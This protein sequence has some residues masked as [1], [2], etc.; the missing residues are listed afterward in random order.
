MKPYVTGAV[1]QMICDFHFI[2]YPP[3]KRKKQKLIEKTRLKVYYGSRMHFLRALYS[4]YP[5]KHGYFINT[6]LDSVSITGYEDMNSWPGIKFI[7]IKRVTP[8]SS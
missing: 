8:T 1:Y 3:E 5:K 6:D 2:P 7:W 4:G